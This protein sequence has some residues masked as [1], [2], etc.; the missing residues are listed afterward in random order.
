MPYVIERH[1]RITATGDHSPRRRVFLQSERQQA[2]GAFSAG[3]AILAK[4]E[5][6]R[7]AVRFGDVRR[8]VLRR[9]LPRRNVTVRAI[10][11]V[12]DDQPA[13]RRQL[14]N[15]RRKLLCECTAAQKVAASIGVRNPGRQTTTISSSIWKQHRACKSSNGKLMMRA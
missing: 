4:Q 15:M 12:G 10:A 13:K 8:R 3:E 1:R 5:I 7:A 6:F 2:L 14:V 11:D 9:D